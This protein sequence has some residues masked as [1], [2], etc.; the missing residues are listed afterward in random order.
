VC[1][2]AA[3]PLI[4]GKQLDARIHPARL[5][6]LGAGGAELESDVPLAVFAP[7]RCCCPPIT[8]A[9]TIG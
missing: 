3:G 7:C 5:L 1:P 9:G 4:F 2:A 6:R 8:N